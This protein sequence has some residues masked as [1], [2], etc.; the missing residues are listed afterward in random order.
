MH[1]LAAP[2][3]APVA[4]AVVAESA[5]YGEIGP[6]SHYAPQPIKTV[7]AAPLTTP[8]TLDKSSA[9]PAAAEKLEPTHHHTIL[10][11]SFTPSLHYEKDAPA[12]KDQWRP[13]EAQSLSLSDET[14]SPAEAAKPKRRKSQDSIAQ[15]VDNSATPAQHEHFEIE[16][17][18]VT[19]VV[20][21]KRET[22]KGVLVVPEDHQ[23]IR[24]NSGLAS[25]TLESQQRAIEPVVI[26]ERRDERIAIAEAEQDTSQFT[27]ESGSYITDGPVDLAPIPEDE[28]LTNIIP[29][30]ST[31]AGDTAVD[32]TALQRSGSKKKKS[33]S[34][35]GSVVSLAE[36]LEQAEEEIPGTITSSVD[37]TRPS[38]PTPSEA[39]FALGDDASGGEQQPKTKLKKKKKSGSQRRKERALKRKSLTDLTQAHQDITTAEGPS[40]SVVKGK[41]TVAANTSTA[42]WNL[43][44]IELSSEDI[45]LEEQNDNTGGVKL[46]VN[47]FFEG[48]QK[49]EEERAKEETRS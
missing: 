22:K 41:V 48:D 49:Q 34:R 19:S 26:G 1:I 17:Q 20:P 45:K 43:G 12:D 10:D 42:E 32:D 14:A 31:A 7:H 5:A 15:L 36:E 40:Q 4:S 30:P 18:A 47:T 6:R 35:R 27:E 37:N 28:P 3:T 11:R 16:S 24:L 25:V 39:S 23:L 21:L 46:G 38:S 9:I 2:I 33:K 8:V 44:S 29:L 13:V